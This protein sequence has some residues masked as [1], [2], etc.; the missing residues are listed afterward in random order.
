MIGQ[1]Q[2]RRPLSAAF[3]QC[4][5]RSNASRF[6]LNRPSLRPL[7]AGD[8]AALA[9]HRTSYIAYVLK[10]PILYSD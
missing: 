3:P 8:I 7:T 9:S 2:F 4:L 10:I 6:A 5:N 1:A